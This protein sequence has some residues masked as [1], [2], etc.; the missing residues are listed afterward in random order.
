VQNPVV[1]SSKD[2]QRKPGELGPSEVSCTTLAISLAARHFD[3]RREQFR[4]TG[5]GGD[6]RRVPNLD[7]VH[8]TCVCSQVLA[9]PCRPLHMLLE[10]PECHCVE[11]VGHGRDVNVR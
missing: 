1:A 10:L 9:L 4:F 11:D 6:K 7:C 2:C 8:P 5:N 3:Q